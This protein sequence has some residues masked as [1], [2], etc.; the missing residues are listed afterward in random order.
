M[1]NRSLEMIISILAVLKAGGTYIP[2]DPEYP[3]DRIEYMLNNSNAKFLL[4]FSSLQ[5]KINFSNMIF[6]KHWYLIIIIF[7]IFI[8]G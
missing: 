4:T 6:N 8:K 2:I 7:L 3:Q 5:Y 1:V